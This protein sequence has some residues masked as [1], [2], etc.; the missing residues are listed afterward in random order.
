[1]N[2]GALRDGASKIMD[3]GCA[4]ILVRDS[5]GNVGYSIVR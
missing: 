5:E 1:V 3:V 2:I 4:Q